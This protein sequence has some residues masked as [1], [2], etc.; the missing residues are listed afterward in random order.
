MRR[1]LA[2]LLSLLV[3]STGHAQIIAFP[4]APGLPGNQCV[5]ENVST[6][7]TLFPGSVPTGTFVTQVTAPSNSS[8]AHTTFDP[9]FLGSGITLSAG[10]LRA[11]GGN[12]TAVSSTRSTTTHGGSDKVYYRATFT[13]TNLNA[14]PGI[15]NVNATT[16]TGGGNNGSAGF[17]PQN[18][19]FLVAGLG[20]TGTAAIANN[21]D[22]ADLAFDFGLGV[23]WI[24]V[25]G[26]G[27]NWN[28]SGAANPSTGA[29]GFSFSTINSG[30]MYIFYS[31][32][33]N[34]TADVTIDPKP[35]LMSDVTLIGFSPWEPFN[36]VTCGAES[37]ALTGADA[38][39]F[40][41]TSPTPPSQIRTVGTDGPG[42]YNV[43]ITATIAGGASNSPLP[44]P[45]S[46]TGT[47]NGI[48]VPGPSSVVY[49]NPFYTCVTNYYVATT[50]S[51]GNS[52]TSIG[53]P[54][55]TLAHAQSGRVAGDCVN[56]AAGLYDQPSLDITSG[57]NAPTVTGYVVYRCATLDG[58]HIL[59]QTPGTYLIGMKAANFVVWDGF[60]VDG[61][62]ALVTNGAATACFDSANDDLG[63]GN[64]S[65]HL[66]FLN[67]IVHHC[68][69]SGFT[70]NNREWYYIYHN[71]VYHDAWESPFQGSGIGMVV[72][73][74]IEQGV[75]ECS[76]SGSYTGGTG[77]YTPSGMDLSFSQ[78]Y[79]IIVAWNNVHDNEIAP[80]NVIGC[81][82]HTDGNGIILDTWLDEATLSLTYP[83]RSLTW[84]NVAWNNGG[85]GI[86]VFATSNATV[87]NNT[88]YGNGTDT[89]LVAFYL[90]DLSQAGGANNQYY[91]NISVSILTAGNNPACPTSVRPFCGARNAPLVA[92]DGRGVVDVNNSYASNIINGGALAGQAALF[93]NDVGYWNCAVNLCATDPAFVNPTSNNFALLTGSPATTFGV[94]VPN[95]L[96]SLVAGS[97]SGQ[98]VDAGA[99]YH[100]VG[101]M[102]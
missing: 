54:W 42:N 30:Q 50:G 24:R 69:L 56:V 21:G 40:V 86:H 3:A 29:G 1:L 53:S 74:C 10:N 91:N 51:D 71:E 28:N 62:D 67:N 34:T 66:W 36:F 80:D 11:Q 76:A 92:G 90:G 49:N 59:A 23:A 88:M 89:C 20:P 17:G 79:H 12:V 84:G 94:N 52:G 44:V 31:S 33:F 26:P 64:S 6:P 68:N 39:K 16:T 48:E 37:L 99:A 38:A 77:T 65:H 83:F 87:A 47:A 60:E 13:N 81:G 100:T 93:S 2:A 101:T 35:T 18:G 97:L 58:C 72:A 98:F 7:N 4:S 27:N 57:G 70:L 45:V 102:P 63:L 55:L 95:D 15:A 41:L 8:G 14:G 73:Q 61:N 82:T 78:P 19:I 85:R 46:L 32:S 96:Y 43:T 25:N 75:A 9:S 22:F 5:L